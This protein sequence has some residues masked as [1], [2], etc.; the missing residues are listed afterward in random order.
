MTDTARNKQ[1]VLDFW[2]AT[3]A[4]KIPFVTDDV[5]WHL[6]ISVTRNGL[7][8]D[9]QGEEVHALFT[10]AGAIY[11]PERTWDIS[12][13]VAEDDLVALHC[14]MHSRTRSGNDYHGPYH[15]LFRIENGLIAEAWEFLDTAYVLERIGPKVEEGPELAPKA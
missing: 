7:A 2:L 3:F 11:E 13:V 8:Q 6:P 9:L 1:L 4:D 5:Q 15:M 10:G 14:T 12:H